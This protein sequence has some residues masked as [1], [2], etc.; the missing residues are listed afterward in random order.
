MLALWE[1]ESCW[2]VG[3]AH[4]NLGSHVENGIL[5]AY[6]NPGPL[7]SREEEEASKPARVA[8]G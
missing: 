3:A 1:S 7:K 5:E 8:R 4:E 2:S 6:F